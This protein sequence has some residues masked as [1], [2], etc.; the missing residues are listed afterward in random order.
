MVGEHGRRW[1]LRLIGICILAGLSSV[2]ALAD[3]TDSAATGFTTEN[4]V[5]IAASP[6]RVYDMLTQQVSAWWDPAHTWSGDASN[7]S[8]DAT[9]GGHFKETIPGG[10]AIHMT[11]VYAHRGKLLRM[12]G[13]LGPL[14]GMAITGSLTWEMHEADGGTEVTVTYAVTGYRAGG[15]A[16]LSVPVDG[17]LKHQLSRLKRYIETGTP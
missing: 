7:L 17:V 2:S 16:L 5:Q 12:S 8:I 3:V 9:P 1:C 14:Q 10:G 11:V 15:L 13:G 6:M 4:R